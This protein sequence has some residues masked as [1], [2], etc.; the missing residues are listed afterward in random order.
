MMDDCMEDEFSQ[1]DANPTPETTPGPALSIAALVLGIACLLC[2]EFVHWAIAI[3]IAIAAIV[4]GV[5]ARRQGAPKR[6]FALAGIIMGAVCLIMYALII[7][8]LAYHIAQ[9]NAAMSV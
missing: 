1:P 8:M 6:G 4:V 2:G 3:L 5:I 7:G 9:I